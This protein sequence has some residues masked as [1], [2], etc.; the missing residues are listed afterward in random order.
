MGHVG[1]SAWTLVVSQVEVGRTGKTKVQ[2]GVG[3]GGT[4][5][6][7]SRIAGTGVVSEEVGRPNKTEVQTLVGVSGTELGRRKM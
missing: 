4:E 1:G 7:E 3:V 6:S 5:V 2:T